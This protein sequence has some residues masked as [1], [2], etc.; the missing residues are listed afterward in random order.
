MVGVAVGVSPRY[1][2][3]A[4][5]GTSMFGI[6]FKAPGGSTMGFSQEATEYALIL[7]R[8]CL[9]SQAGHSWFVD[10]GFDIVRAGKGFRKFEIES[11]NLNG[12]GTH[13]IGAPIDG[14]SARVGVRLGAGREWSLSRH[15]HVALQ[16]IASIGLSDLRRYRLQNVTWQQGQTI[17]P[18]S[19]DVLIATRFS[20]VGVQ[21]R[22]RFQL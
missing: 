22:Y 12:P 16:A 15:H 18:V 5:V 6:G 7:R 1:A 2:V 11:S 19:K 4:T 13:V 10:S 9:V 21:A 14:K 3:Q 8:Q 17:D 20:F